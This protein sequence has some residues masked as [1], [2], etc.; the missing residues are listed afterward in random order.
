L[1]RLNRR[2]FVFLTLSLILGW[3]WHHFKGMPFGNVSPRAGLPADVPAL[4]EYADYRE[5]FRTDSTVLAADFAFTKS[6][7]EELALLGRVLEFWSPHLDTGSKVSLTAGLHGVGT[8]K[9]SASLLLDT[10]RP[11]FDLAP[12]LAH[13]EVRRVLPSTYQGRKIYTVYL[14]N[15]RTF[16]VAQYRNLLIVSALPLLVEEA[17]GRLEWRPSGLSAQKGFK[18][19]LPAGKSKKEA[20]TARLYLQPA[21]LPVLLSGI[22]HPKG[23]TE[24]RRWASLADWL[25]LDL[26]QAK[27]GWTIAGALYPAA[28]AGW[29]AAFQNRPQ[30]IPSGQLEIIPDNTAFLLLGAVANWNGML[31][32]E[33]A[34]FRK[35]IAS[36]AGKEMALAMA[37]PK[38][39]ELPS[40]WFAVIQVRNKDLAERRLEALGEETGI[41]KDY[42]YQSFRIRQL[43]TE[44]LLPLA[45]PGWME[46]PFFAFLGDYA[47][48]ASSQAG[49][50]VWID[51]YI[52]GKTLASDEAFLPLYTHGKEEGAWFLYMP[53]GKIKPL[54]QAYAPGEPLFAGLIESLGTV[55]IGAQKGRNT[56]DLQGA[57]LKQGAESPHSAVAWKALL[58]AP[59]LSRP[60]AIPETLGGATCIAIQD[61][62]HR[63]YLI[64]PTGEIRWSK[65]LEGPLLSDVQR[66]DY[67]RDGSAALLMNTAHNIY[68]LDMKG[69]DVGNF[70]LP[71]QSAATNGVTVVNFDGGMQ[72]CFFVAC[73]NGNLYGFDRLGRP[74]PGW[75]PLPGAGVLRFPVLHFFKEDKDYLIALNDKG[76]MQVFRRDGGERMPARRL[77]GAFLSPPDFQVSD[78]S[79]R[80]VAM[81][82]AGTVHVVGLKNEY[83]RLACPVGEGKNVRMAFGEFSGDERKDYVALSGHDLALYAYGEG[84]SFGK[85]FEHRFDTP[86]DEVFSVRFPGEPADHIGTVSREAGRIHLLDAKGAPFPGFPLAGHTR[87]FA[88]DLYQNGRVVVVAAYGD[89]VYAYQ[90]Q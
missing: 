31:G 41:L 76:L 9:V 32:Q 8:G 51:A 73:A 25:R 69:D 62:M 44:R 38:G 80:I 7:R 59:A 74:L 40:D 36:W 23:L 17:V 49:M 63:L 42:E 22:V 39:I 27:N 67:Y 65:Q 79:N 33:P 64:G 60:F 66:M 77:D 85:I 81:N 28:G 15:R 87:F 29:A 55:A 14:D 3:A 71:L 16:A 54:L 58:S 2:L 78:N 46:N 68:L 48:F 37:Q 34:Q 1:N 88:A 86:Q 47:V 50:E 56:W 35:Y 53:A 18:K 83:F 43:M 6:L 90:I 19:I 72:I 4:I 13:A 26:Q 89:S 12:L 20:P 82:S 75:N 57:S 24:L 70:P 45:S 11:G 21:Q 30:L 5:A 61:S 52:S 84:S 10:R